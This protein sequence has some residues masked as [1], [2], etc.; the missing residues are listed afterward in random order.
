MYKRQS[1]LCSPS[2]R[3]TGSSSLDDGDAAGMLHHLVHILRRMR[4]EGAEREDHAL[5]FLEQLNDRRRHLHRRRLRFRDEIFNDDSDDSD[6]NDDGNDDDDDD[7]D[8]DGMSSVKAQYSVSS[9]SSGSNQVLRPSVQPMD[10][11]SHPAHCLTGEWPNVRLRP[12]DERDILP[13][14]T[15]P[16]RQRD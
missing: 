14:L 5:D 10:D 11:Y 6:N 8:D 4:Q 3:S 12:I 2:P 16:P 7:D 1:L 13:P 9:T 15:P